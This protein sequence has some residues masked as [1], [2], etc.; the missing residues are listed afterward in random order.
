MP[1]PEFSAE[2]QQQ[3]ERRAAHCRALGNRQRI[4]I[5]WLLVERERTVTELAAALGASLP[6]TSHHLR[7]LEFGQL[8]KNRR[9]HQNI[10]YSLAENDE[11]KYCPILHNSPIQQIEPV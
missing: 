8:V 4:L 3:A 2:I 9:E 6:A 10:Y 5:L 7:I 11:V 1:T